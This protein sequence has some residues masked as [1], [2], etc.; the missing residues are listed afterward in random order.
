MLAPVLRR[1]YSTSSKNEEARNY[2]DVEGQS[3][4]GDGVSAIALVRRCVLRQRRR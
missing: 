1:A 2:G 3:R 4:H